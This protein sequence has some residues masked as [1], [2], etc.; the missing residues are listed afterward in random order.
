MLIKRFS[1]KR[2]FET[3]LNLVNILDSEDNSILDYGTGD[4]YFLTEAAQKYQKISL[5]GFEPCKEQY[6]LATRMSSRYNNIKI[7]SDVKEIQANQFNIITCFEVLEHLPEKEAALVLSN[8]RRLLKDDGQLIISVPLES[9]LSGFV[10]NAVRLLINQ[11]HTSDMRK[12]T[13]A[14]LGL[15]VKRAG[16]EYYLDGHIGFRHKDLEPLLLRNFQLIATSFS[17]F[18][19]F[20]AAINSQIF[21][22][23]I[24]RK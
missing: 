3:S 2:R 18:P 4:G 11:P 13:R 15:K 23:L 21:Y 24:K 12:M 22:T 16:A 9:G 20:K 8:V 14:M 6:K 10:K 1:H 19:F 5:V 7:F 17:P